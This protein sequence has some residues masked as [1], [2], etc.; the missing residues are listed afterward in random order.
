MNDWMLTVKI[1]FHNH[2]PTL[3]ES[4]PALRKMTL[5]EEIIDVIKRQSRVN[6]LP[7]KILSELRFDINEEN[8]MF[9]PQNIY[10]AKT[11]I[12]RQMFETFTSV[13]TLMQQL[14]KKN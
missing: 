14:K 1:F 12:K 4:H 5:N 8:S 13:Q 7:A 6:I 11:E 3:S 10:N 9:K 2:T